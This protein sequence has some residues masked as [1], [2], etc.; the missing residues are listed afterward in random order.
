[1][2]AER[3]LIN[4]FMSK[5]HIQGNLK[6]RIQMYVEYKYEEGLEEN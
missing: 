1:V 3:H 5:R 4:A 2:A 6:E